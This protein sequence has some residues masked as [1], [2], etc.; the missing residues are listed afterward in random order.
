[1]DSASPQEKN[2]LSRL[3]HDLRTPINHILGY[4]E[5]IGEELEDEGATAHVSDLRKVRD[6]AQTLLRMINANLSDEGV[7]ALLAGE[8]G[9]LPAGKKSGPAIPDCDDSPAP[10][11][12]KILVV[13]DNR[14]NREMLSRRLDRQGHTTAQAADGAAALERL[15]SES[16]DLVLLDVM[17]PGIDGTEVLRTMKRDRALRSIPVIMISA[18]DELESLVSCIEAGAEDYLP[19]PFEPTLLRA[20]IGASLEKKHLRDQE[21]HYL[22][23]I[24]QTQRRLGKELEEAANYVRSILPPPVEARGVKA[25]WRFEPSTEL[26]GDSFGYHWLDDEHFAIYLLDVCGHGVG[27]ALLSVAAANRLRMVNSGGVDYRDPAAVLTMLNEAFPMEQHNQ[28]YF[29]IWYG[30]YH[31]PT[32]R[33]RHASGGHPPAFL[34]EGEGIVELREPGL[35]VGVMPGVRYQ[36]GEVMLKP[37]ARLW[38]MSDGTYEIRL[39]DEP[40]GMLAYEEFRA[41]FEQ[42]GREDNFPDRLE[43]WIRGLNGPGALD[44][45]FSIVQLDFLA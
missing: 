25:T 16:Y 26:G 32:G 20:R 36:S 38:M 7:R 33:L 27:A 43:Q 41:F 34:L 6:A 35:V 4:A 19:K 24:E 37:G 14:E 18:L 13:D 10:V 12:G 30:V 22:Q 31:R 29:T 8:A 45:D 3:R 17:M 5:L 9:Q 21:Q 42:H 44:D 39:P 28:M 11:T 40:G 1:M 2:A 23:T 15:R